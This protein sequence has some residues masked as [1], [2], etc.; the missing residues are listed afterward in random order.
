MTEILIIYDGDDADENALVNTIC[1]SK[2]PQI[3]FDG[4]RIG[5]SAFLLPSANIN[6][7][8]LK[9]LRESIRRGSLHWVRIEGHM[10]QSQV[11]GAQ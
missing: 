9:Q 3:W 11:G 10:L 7:M 4:R 6:E 1:M 8:R 2:T 5:P